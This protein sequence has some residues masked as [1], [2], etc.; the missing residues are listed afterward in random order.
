MTVPPSLPT[1][2]R[3]DATRTALVHVGR[4]RAVSGALDSAFLR[5]KMHIARTH[6]AVSLAQRQERTAMLLKRLGHISPA[7]ENNPVPGGV[8]FGYF[9]ENAFRSAFSTGTAIALGYVCPALP[10][11]NVSSVLYTTSTNRASSGVEALVAWDIGEQVSFQV[12]DWSHGPQDRWVINMSFAELSP[13][14]TSQVIAAQAQP[15]MWVQ[16]STFE[17]S[18]GSWTNRVELYDRTTQGWSSIYSNTYQTTLASQLNGWVGSWGPIVETFQPSFS[19]TNPLGVVG[20]SLRSA[21]V[22]GNWGA[23]ANLDAS[24]S[25]PRDDHVGFHAT[26]LDPNYDWLLSS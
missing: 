8:G 26:S 7:L 18:P 24:Q 17:S 14:L 13:Y 21:D 6:P 3:V 9:Y 25:D 16:N 23:W 12:Y 10:G 15:V 20:V 22:N 1:G 4:M 2:D 11:G 19:G 5:S